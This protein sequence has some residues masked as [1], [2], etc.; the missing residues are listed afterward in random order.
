MVTDP[1]N[2]VND[3]SAA[4]ASGFTFHLEATGMYTSVILLGRRV[5]LN[6]RKKCY[7]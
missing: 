6:L 3:F 4:G 7:K 2:W 1:D 5:V